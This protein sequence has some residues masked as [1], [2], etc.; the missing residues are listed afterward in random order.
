MTAHS[1]F[2]DIHAIPPQNTKKNPW[3]FAGA[4]QND[5]ITPGE[6]NWHKVTVD[7]H[8]RGAATV[9]LLAC[10][11]PGNHPTS[12]R[13]SRAVAL[14]RLCQ[15]VLDSE[16]YY[17]SRGVTVRSEEILARFLGWAKDEALSS[18]DRTLLYS[19]TPRSLRR[20]VD[21]YQEALA[22]A[23]HLQAFPATFSKEGSRL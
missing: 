16:D 9:A 1:L 3:M 11:P 5:A 23:S 10:M 8:L 13:I 17:A 7:N 22:D 18:A 21:I 14:V 15:T 20:F 6:G 19:L 12:V 2:D 4:V